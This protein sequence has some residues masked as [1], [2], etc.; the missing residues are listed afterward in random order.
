MEASAGPLLDFLATG[1]PASDPLSSSSLARRL[2]AFRGI[3]VVEVSRVV[4][5]GFG[6]AQRCK[7]VGGWG[8]EEVN[9]GC[10]LVTR[11]ENQGDGWWKGSA[12]GRRVRG[13][14][15]SSSSVTDGR[16][17]GRVEAGPD[18]ARCLAHVVIRSRPVRSSPEFGNW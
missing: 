4:L 5:R 7:N 8:G 15:E 6:R 12:T 10:A 16:A 18:K 14:T 1:A 3:L 13:N 11:E 17:F 2:M 9:I